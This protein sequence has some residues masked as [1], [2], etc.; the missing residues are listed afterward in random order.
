MRECAI[1]GI[2]QAFT[3][4]GN[5]KGNADTERTMRT[6]KEELFGLR[7]WFSLEHLPTRFLTG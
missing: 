5:P 2:S 6:I 1:L 3:S 4:Y 7:E